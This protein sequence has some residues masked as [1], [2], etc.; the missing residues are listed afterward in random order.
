[1]RSFGSA[2]LR[3]ALSAPTTRRAYSESWR[4][5]LRGDSPACRATSLRTASASSGL[6]AAT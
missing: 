3:L 2:G 1:M 4:G 5:L 6:R